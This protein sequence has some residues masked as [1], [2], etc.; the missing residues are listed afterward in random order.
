MSHWFFLIIAIILEVAGTTSMKLS[1]GFS[2]WLPSILIFVFYGLSFAGLTLALKRI[3]VSIAYAIWA[4]LGT[5][6]IT[7][8]GLVYFKE[9]A[10][11]IKLISIGL[12]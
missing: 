3:D 5:A 9:P 1:E 6:L 4:G 7:V 12:I 8:I 2:R 11:L 10:T